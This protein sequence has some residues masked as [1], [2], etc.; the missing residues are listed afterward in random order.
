MTSKGRMMLAIALAAGALGIV[1]IGVVI[2]TNT[3]SF[4]RGSLIN[5]SSITVGAAPVRPLAEYA[6]ASK[7]VVDALAAALSAGDD[8]ALPAASIRTKNALM[9]LTVPPEALEKHL[10]LVRTITAFEQDPS[11]EA[12]AALAAAVEAF[13]R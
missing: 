4:V 12:R 7:E 10:R 3:F 1:V 2:A 5:G 13:S 9:N 11:P 8:A 6:T